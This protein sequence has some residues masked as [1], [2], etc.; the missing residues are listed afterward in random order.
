MKTSILVAMILLR[1]TTL[2]SEAAAAAG[3]SCDPQDVDKVCCTAEMHDACRFILQREGDENHRQTF[4]WVIVSDADAARSIYTALRDRHK[5]ASQIQDKLVALGYPVN[6]NRMETIDEGLRLFDRVTHKLTTKTSSDSRSESKERL[7]RLQHHLNSLIQAYIGLFDSWFEGLGLHLAPMN[8]W[9]A[10]YDNGAFKTTIQMYSPELL[11]L[12]FALVDHLADGMEKD[13]DYITKR[14]ED[15]PLREK[16]VDVVLENKWSAACYS[17]ENYA[18]PMDTQSRVY[19]HVSKVCPSLWCLMQYQLKSEKNF[20]SAAMKALE[21]YDVENMGAGPR[22]T[23]VDMA[24]LKLDKCV[25]CQDRW[26]D[27]AFYPCGHAV[28]C[29]Q[30]ANSLDQCPTCRQNPVQV[31]K[32]YGLALPGS[33]AEQDENDA[34]KQPRPDDVSDQPT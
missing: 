11:L 17:T 25:I 1:L 26:I 22:R 12:W 20:K 18:Q 4:P 27:C 5:V 34:E 8:D 30:C 32:L 7:R 21:I 3:P 28:S 2:P 10:R 15:I 33:E 23:I 24:A 6:E 14:L 9:M 13:P 16:T 29:L 19:L 31:I